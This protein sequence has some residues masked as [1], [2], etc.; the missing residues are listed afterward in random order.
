[1]NSF[2][3]NEFAFNFSTH[4]EAWKITTVTSLITESD[5]TEKFE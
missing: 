3:K 2:V 4:K 1:M 5:D